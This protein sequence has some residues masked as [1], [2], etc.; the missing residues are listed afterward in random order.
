MS[1]FEEQKRLDAE[2][3][4]MAASG[5]T[6][7]SKVPVFVATIK[8]Y[9]CA[10]GH[11]WDGLTASHPYFKVTGEIAGKG[12]IVATS[13]PCP[14]CYVEFFKALPQAEEVKDGG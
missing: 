3:W 14:F 5:A 2:L 7:A 9:R 4:A 6:A 1:D 12:M 8:R 11:E 10:K 13:D